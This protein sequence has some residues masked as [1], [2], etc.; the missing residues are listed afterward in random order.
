MT[1]PSTAILRRND[2][3]DPRKMVPDASLARLRPPRLLEPG[4]DCGGLRRGAFVTA[5]KSTMAQRSRTSSTVQAASGDAPGQP[6]R[7]C[8]SAAL[9]DPKQLPTQRRCNIMHNAQCSRT[10]RL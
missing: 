8:H 7:G 5:G 9:P 6:R 4:L 2:S 10:P 3:N 1:V